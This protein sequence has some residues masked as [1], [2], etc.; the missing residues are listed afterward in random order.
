MSESGEIRRRAGETMDGLRDRVGGLTL[1]D[2]AGQSVDLPGT[3]S[4]VTN[5]PG[6]LRYREELERMPG[7]TEEQANAAAEGWCRRLYAGT[8]TLPPITVGEFITEPGS[9]ASFLGLDDA[10]PRFDVTLTYGPKRRHRRL[11]RGGNAR[12]RR[13]TRRWLARHSRAL[14]G[15]ELR[16]APSDGDRIGVEFVGGVLS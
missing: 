8:R 16:M 7:I 5:P 10:P 1:T 15:A 13:R 3:V 4:I 14:L 11:A 2:A 9:L 6:A 12:D